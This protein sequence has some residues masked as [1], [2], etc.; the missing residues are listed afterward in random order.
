MLDTVRS[1][2]LG[3]TQ[4]NVT[5][6][7]EMADIQRRL[8]DGDATLGWGGEPSLTIHLAVEVDDFGNPKRNG[9]VRFEVWGLDAHRQPYMALSWPR[10]DLSLIRR[11][12]EID[13]RRAPVLDRII[14]ENAAAEKAKKDA[15]AE[16]RGEMVEKFAHA[17]QRDLG[18]HH[19]GLRKNIH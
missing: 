19:G 8:T 17:L 15:A 6:T 2:F 4:V 10:C 18:H 14:K 3:N 7:G 16:Q 11:L 1:A 12:V 9:D 5:V 13:N